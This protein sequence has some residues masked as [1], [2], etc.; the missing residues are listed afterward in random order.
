MF[1]FPWKTN[2]TWVFYPQ[3]ANNTFGIAFNV[4]QKCN[5]VSILGLGA[6]GGGG[7]GRGSA[8]STIASGGGGGGSGGIV[9]LQIPR[10]FLPDLLFLCVGTGGAGGTGGTA[11][12]GSAGTAGGITYVSLAPNNTSSNILLRS[13][14][15]SAGGGNG[16]TATTGGTGGAAA[17]ITTNTNQGWGNIALWLSLAGIIGAAGGDNGTIGN[18]ITPLASIPLG[19]GGAGGGG[20]LADNAS[21]NYGGSIL[22]NGLFS[23]VAASPGAGNDKL[24][25]G[26]HF[27][28]K[29]LLST[30]GTGG[31][32]TVGAATVGGLGGLG[33]YGSGGG[34]G[35]GTSGAGAT[36]GKGGRG[37][38][39]L[40][41]ITAW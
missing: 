36:G 16:G 9:R 15:G 17:T 32:G 22:A 10:I 2:K 20:C 24:I 12:N 39:G 26:G 13:N 40:I 25:V 7:G 8:A 19:T 29:P 27:R 23:T 11:A 21:S 31:P 37:G 14:T 5:T 41:I 33:G 28:L 3:T 6:G 34:G 38:D 30:G 35:G 4:P 1:G 18:D